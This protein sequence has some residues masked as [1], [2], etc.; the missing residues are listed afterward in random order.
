MWTI[1]VFS[2]ESRKPHREKHR[3]CLVSQALGVG[4]VPGHHDHPVVRVADEAVVG[5]A[6]ASALLPLMRVA[7]RLP[8]RDEVLVEDRQG[9]VGK[10]RREN[11]ALRGTGVVVPKLA[12]L[13]EDAGLQERLHQAQ[14]AFV[15]DPTSHTA[16]QRG[17]VDLVEARLDVAF[18]DPLIR[19][20]REVVDL[21]DRVLGSALRAEAVTDRLEVRLEDRLEHQS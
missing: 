8:G 13:T 17:V 11:P 4:S 9:D 6:L 12:I 7:H 5:Q 21:G 16:H 20:A 2:S 19:A 18:H 14:D 3:C 15:P 10:Q 1:F